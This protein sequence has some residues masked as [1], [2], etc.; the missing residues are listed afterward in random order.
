M[1]V[2][3]REGELGDEGVRVERWSA[4]GDAVQVG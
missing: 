2:R 3:L 4:G 1:V